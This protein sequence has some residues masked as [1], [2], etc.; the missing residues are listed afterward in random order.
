MLNL[1]FLVCLYPAASALAGHFLWLVL[2]HLLLDVFTII[3]QIIVPFATGLFS[4]NERGKVLGSVAF[5]L[6][7]GI[8]QIKK[9]SLINLDTYLRV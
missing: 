2:A 9:R 5:G 1:L 6:V 8:T 7:C 4:E 3:P